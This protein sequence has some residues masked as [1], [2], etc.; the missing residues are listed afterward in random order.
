MAERK[1]DLLHPRHEQFIVNQGKE[2]ARYGK[3]L[4]RPDDAVLQSPN[5]VD[6][7]GRVLPISEDLS[8]MNSGYTWRQHESCSEGSHVNN[9][10]YAAFKEVHQH[11]LGK[12]SCDEYL[13]E[14]MS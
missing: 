14:F 7:E 12:F 4:D 9:T 6:H 10:E 8:T 1:Q 13:L 11:V 2:R 5:G 3:S